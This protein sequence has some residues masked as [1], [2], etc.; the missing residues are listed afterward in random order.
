MNE[1]L[2]KQIAAI[3]QAA[4]NAAEKGGQWLGGQIPDVLH[5]LI[6]WTITKGAVCLLVLIASIAAVPFLYRFAANRN[7]TSDGLIWIPFVFVMV[8]MASIVGFGVVPCIGDGL[9]ALVAP[10]LFL[11]EYVTHL[12]HP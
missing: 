3:L 5:Q 1:E 9:Q 12:V 8:A 6:V 10:K 2:Q 11:L 4:L 7:D